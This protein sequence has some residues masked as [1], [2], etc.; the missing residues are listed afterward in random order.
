[1]SLPVA[2]QTVYI[3][4]LH[5]ADRGSARVLDMDEKVIFLDEPWTVDR[6]RPLGLNEQDDI[7]VSY[8]LTDGSLCHFETSVLR[9]KAQLEQLWTTTV[10][11][12]NKDQ[13]QRVQRR[14]YARVGAEMNLSFSC[15]H[16]D[17]I[18]TGKGVTR[19]LSAGGLSFWP[20]SGDGL[21]TG[22]IMEIVL[23]IPGDGSVRDEVS[24]KGIVLRADPVN[25]LT[26][27]CSLRFQEMSLIA[28]QRIV[29]FVFKRQIEL[30]GKGL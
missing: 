26:T 25:E 7:R 17:Q 11:R 4:K 1:M 16:Q 3:D 5:S 9:V 28:E 27:I 20:K 6:E 14:Q 13:I 22:D 12:P 2:G 15:M 8:R 18:I 23:Q 29:R 10:R 24:A 21:A 30:R 19:D